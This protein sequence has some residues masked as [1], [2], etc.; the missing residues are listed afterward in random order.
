MR[1]R[2]TDLRRG[3]LSLAVLLTAGSQAFAGRASDLAH[4][5]IASE[6]S[7]QYRAVGSWEERQCDGHMATASIELRRRPGA[8]WVRVTRGTPAAQ[9]VQYADTGQGVDIW[10]PS[11]KRLYKLK[12]ATAAMA[13][14]RLYGIEP[15][16]AQGEMRYVGEETIANRPAYRLRIAL[17][18]RRP[19]VHDVWV[20]KARFVA[21]KIA[22][23]HGGRPWRVM[24]FDHFNGEAELGDDDFRVQAP[25]DAK[26]V[27]G[28]AGRRAEPMRIGSAQDAAQQYGVRVMSPTWLPA[29][30][31]FDAVLTSQPHPAGLLRRRILVRFVKGDRVLVLMMGQTGPKTEADEDEPDTPTKPTEVKPGL[32]LWVKEAVRLVLVGPR[33]ID[34]G[35]LRR[36]A[37]S[38]TWHDAG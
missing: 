30:Y 24:Q 9:G 7:A 19:V 5:W 37:E 23:Q 3:L 16:A 32:F 36:C 8:I 22:T 14:P 11:E 15:A 18:T 17:K 25:D 26:V 34:G 28:G 2:S 38:V 6:K 29:G 27:Q 31:A 20:D 1:R 4:R 10:V 13:V 21:L 35:E 33:D 12:E